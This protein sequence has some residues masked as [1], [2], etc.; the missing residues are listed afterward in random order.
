QTAEQNKQT[1][2]DGLK[3]M[4]TAYQEEENKKDGR[5]KVSEKLNRLKEYLPAVK[6]IDDRKNHLHQLEAKVKEAFKSL[7]AVQADV[8]DKKK[9]A[10]DYQKNIK[11]KDESVRKLQDKHLLLK[12]IR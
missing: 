1:A 2:D 8:K 6:E 7:Q 3:R 9:Q 4:E 12:K 10:E 11:N 5:E